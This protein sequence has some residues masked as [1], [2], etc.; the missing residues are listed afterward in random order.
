MEH[1]KE[2]SLEELALVADFMDKDKIFVKV[3]IPIIT[4]R[5]TKFY[6]KNKGDFTI[7]M[8]NLNKNIDLPLGNLEY[9]GEKDTLKGIINNYFQDDLYD[10]YFD[11]IWEIKEEKII[12]LAKDFIN[13]NLDIKPYINVDCDLTDLVYGYSQANL[14]TKITSFIIETIEDYIYI[15]FFKYGLENLVLE[16]GRSL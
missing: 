5:L 2:K 16:F 4:E 13:E 7:Y 1:N 14:K 11:E 15:D 6:I 12:K 3:I 10:T 8:T 9:I